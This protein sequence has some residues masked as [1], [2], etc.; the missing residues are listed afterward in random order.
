MRSA[1][2]ETLLHA[3]AAA[4]HLAAVEYLCTAEDPDCDINAS[5]QDGNTVLHFAVKDDRLPVVR[6]L[7]ERGADVNARNHNSDTPLHWAVYRGH[8]EIIE[9]LVALQSVDVNV[10]DRYQRTPLQSAAG[11]GMVDTVRLL[12]GRR[13]DANAVDRD[14][15]TVVMDAAWSGHVEIVKLLLQAGA[16]LEKGDDGRDAIDVLRDFEG[17]GLPLS[18]DFDAIVS[19]LRSA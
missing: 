18:E 10:R 6:L 11:K 14:G 13:A 17:N 3:A 5:N 4:G 7:V 9:Y 15:R 19:Q 2:G 8:G 16:R 1:S 12:L